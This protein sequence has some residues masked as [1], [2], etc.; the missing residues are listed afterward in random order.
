MTITPHRAPA[1]PTGDTE[2]RAWVPGRVKPSLIIATVLSLLSPHAY[3]AS[4]TKPDVKL[5]PDPRMSYE[6]TAT[7][8]GAP[9]TFESVEG[10]VDYKVTNLA[11]VPVTHGSGATVEPQ[12]RVPVVF[13]R[14]AAGV[15]KGVVHLDQIQDE[16][17]FGL[18][19][20]HWSIVGTSV[21]FHHDQVNFSPAIYLDDILNGTNF[22][23]Y[24]SIKSYENASRDRIDIGAPSKS[25][26]DEP[27]RTFAITLKASGTNS[28]KQGGAATLYTPAPTGVQTRQAVPSQSPSITDMP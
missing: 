1:V 6:I 22:V 10:S 5:N 26:Y 9:G 16:D 18:G 21:D 12:K 23:R 25:A 19:V 13:K 20:C 7:V 11:S 27:S 28:L 17:Y 3:G 15:Y 2:I 14:V 4:V 8:T 24:F